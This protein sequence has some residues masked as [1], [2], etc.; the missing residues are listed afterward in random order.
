M[1][2]TDLMPILLDA[3]RAEINDYRGQPDTPENSRAAAGIVQHYTSRAQ[4]LDLTLS[5]SAARALLA[6]TYKKG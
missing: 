1:R 4:L 6:T 3:F 2:S 5:E